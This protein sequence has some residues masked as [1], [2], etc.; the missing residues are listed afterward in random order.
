[1]LNNK[2]DCVERKVPRGTKRESIPSGAKTLCLPSSPNPES[3]MTGFREL[4]LCLPSPK[5]GRGAGGEGT[6]LSTP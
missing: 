1:M 3:H 6:D 2:K 4:E 5:N